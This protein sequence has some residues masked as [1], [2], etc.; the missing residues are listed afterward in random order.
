MKSSPY[1]RVEDITH[2]V[3]ED[4]LR[5]PPPF[6]GVQQVAVDRDVEAVRVPRVSH[7][8]QTFRQPFGIAVFASRADFVASCDWGSR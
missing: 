7:G 3:H 8:M 2:G 1:V 4:K 5:L 6:W